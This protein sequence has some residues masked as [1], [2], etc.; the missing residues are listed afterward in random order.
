MLT[1]CPVR[2]T[3]C[4]E[5]QSKCGACGPGVI[6]PG[7]GG[8]KWKSGW[9]PFI[10]PHPVDPDV[11]RDPTKWRKFVESLPK[12]PRWF[13]PK[14]MVDGFLV[15]ADTPRP[16]QKWELD[17]NDLYQRHFR[18]KDPASGG[19]V[20]GI[21]FIWPGQGHPDPVNGTLTQGG[22]YRGSFWIR[23]SVEPRGY[24]RYFDHKNARFFHW[25]GIEV[26]P[27]QKDKAHQMFRWVLVT[28]KPPPLGWHP[29]K[30]TYK[31]TNARGQERYV[32]TYIMPVGPLPQGVTRVELRLT[33]PQS[34][35]FLAMERHTVTIP[36]K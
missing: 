28:P 11:F 34:G 3:R 19:Q 20:E 33:H 14:S 23:P 27:E 31:Y 22:T 8:G 13:E 18:E 29:A 7:P 35:A 4:P 30:T 26:P 10:V 6:P 12:P 1:K 32:F 16:G 36:R 17:R 5:V 2:E 25:V 9:D 21:D 24:I 15:L